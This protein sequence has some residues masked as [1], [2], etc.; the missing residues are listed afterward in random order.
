MTTGFCLSKRYTSCNSIRW[1]TG[2]RLLFPW[3]KKCLGVQSKSAGSGINMFDCDEN[4]ELQ[5][6]ECRNETILALKDQDLYVELTADNTA[7][8]S[9]TVGANNHL[10]ISGTSSGACMKTYRE[11]YTI[12]GNANGKFCMFPFLYKDRWYS[13]CSVDDSPGNRLWCSVE[14]KYEHELWGYCPTNTK[15]SWN[16][17]PTTGAYYQLNTESALT[18]PQ[19][20]VSCKQQ[21]ASLLSITDPHQQAYVTGDK[22]WIGQIL[23]QEHGWH[24]SNGQPYRYMNWD[25]GY[26]LLNPG[27]YCAIMNGAV[28]YAWQSSTC[29]KKLGYI[30]YVEGVTS[31]P[32][33]ASETGFCSSPWVPY[34]GHCFYLNRT[35][36]T[37]PDAFKD[38]RKEGG[39]LASIHNMGEQSFAISQLGFAAGD[40]VWIGLNDRQVEGLFDWTDHSTVRFTSWGYGNPQLKSDQEDCV[41]IRGEKGNWADGFCD[42]KHGFICKKR[43]APELPGEE[44]VQ[45]IG[46]KS[47]WKRHGSYC[48]FVGT[49]TKTFDE[50]KDHCESLNSYLVDVSN[51][52][53]N[54][55]LISLIGMRAEKHFWIGLSNRL[56]LD[57][58]VWTNKVAVTFTHWNRGM[59]GHLQG[60]VAMTAGAHTGLWDVLPCTN[61]TKYICKHLAEGAVLTTVQPTN[62]PPDCAEGWTPL[63]SK[64]Y[65][66][67]PHANKTT[68]FEARDYCI[69]IGG[70]L[71]SIHSTTELK[72]LFSSSKS[73]FLYKTFWIGFNAPDPG[74]GYVWSDG[75]PVNFQNWAENEPNNRNNMES[76]AEMS[77]YHQRWPWKD[78]HCEKNN[79][80]L[81]QIRAGDTPKQPPEPVMPDYNTTSDG[82][83]EWKGNQY[84]I[85]YNSPMAVEDARHFCKQRHGDLVSINSE[86]ENIFLWQ[87]RSHYSGYFWIGLSLDLDRTFQWMDG[88]QVVFELWDDKQPKFSNYDE[89]CGVILD[90]FWYNSNCG[91]EH[92]FICKRTGSVP[93]NT[94]VAPTEIPK[95]GCPPSWVKFNAKC[96][97]IIEN[98]KVTW[99]DARIQCQSMGGNL[100]SIPSRQVEVFLINRMA[101]KPASDHWIGLFASESNWLFWSDGQKRRYINMNLKVGTENLNY[102]LQKILTTQGLFLINFYH[103]PI[104]QKICVAF[105]TDAIFGVARWIEKSCNDTNGYICHQNINPSLPETPGITISGDYVR[106]LNDSV[107]AVTQLMKWEDARHHCEVDDAQLISLRNGWLQAYV[108]L[109]AVTLKTPVWIGLNNLQTSGYFR[110]I[111]GWH[112]IL[113]RWGIEEPSK[114]RPCVYVDIDGKWKTAYCNETMNSVCMK[115]RDVPPTDVSDY[116]GYCAEEVQS[117]DLLVLFGCK[118]FHEVDN[119]QFSF[120]Q[121]ASLASIGDPSEQEFI[122]KHI[123]VFEDIHSSFWIGLFKS[124]RGTWKWLDA[125]VMDY[126]NW[127]KDQ[128]F[129][130]IHGEISTSDGMWLTA[131]MQSYRP[132]ICKKQKVME[133]MHRSYAALTALLVIAG[134]A[135]ATVAIVFIL[136]RH[137]H[138][139]ILEN[140]TFPNP[141]FFGNE[142]NRSDTRLIA[143][144][145]E[146]NPEP[147]VTM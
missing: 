139:P 64:H 53:D 27:H 129:D 93:A 60:C 47:N 96:Y 95:G 22:L 81:C 32:T 104:L 86:A 118:F 68:W 131:E 134:I 21:G 3:N 51:G 1:T 16:R 34:S 91:N 77:I 36:R 99:D 72:T 121:G 100:V 136:R 42:E 7:V 54:M 128:P 101:E 126:A 46:C 132:Y 92:N 19:A 62:F 94:T 137:Y 25:S 87:Q 89:T 90:G 13:D 127:G 40:A 98:P 61:K 122:E 2:D 23:N 110:F 85:E 88:S 82:W 83:L 114:K 37:W 5:K 35:Q 120:C 144:N 75:S 103:F 73:E 142:Q 147:M 38:C 6:W 52:M 58:F 44:I 39:D 130:H 45:N 65:C 8:L 117:S 26:P 78:I 141:L 143:E 145:A 70:E 133:S 116:P 76:C 108:E 48:Y 105:S 28:M 135:L 71:L 10:T 55:F 125:S 49:E 146:E 138:L 84:F 111:D 50:A 67:K 123:K 102:D 119:E 43:S 31:H 109:L 112:V 11:L 66:A 140:L 59:P 97:S 33:D 12:G 4:S 15:D 69:A 9:K 115:S 20:A 113:S 80:W 29:T 57:Y 24:W 30:C 79:N 63:P 14:T 107:K 106:I 74:T 56:H 17:H 18:W 41:F 124:N